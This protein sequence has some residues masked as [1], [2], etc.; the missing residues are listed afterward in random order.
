MAPFGQEGHPA[1]C[2]LLDFWHC[3]VVQEVGQPHLFV[4]HIMA[5]SQVTWYVHTLW[6]LGVE[7]AVVEVV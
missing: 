4:A 6:L 2:L 7:A 1:A 3:L 5:E